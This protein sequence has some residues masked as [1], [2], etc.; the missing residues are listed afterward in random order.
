LDTHK[1]KRKLDYPSEYQNI[2]KKYKDFNSLAAMGVNN[3]ETIKAVQQVIEENK[4]LKLHIKDLENVIEAV[5]KDVKSLKVSNTEYQSEARDNENTLVKKIEQ[6]QMENNRFRT[7]LSSMKNPM[8]DKREAYLKT[9]KLEKIVDLFV[10]FFDKNVARKE[11]RKKYDDGD[12]DGMMDE[13]DYLNKRYY[14]DR[15]S[16]NSPKNYE[17]NDKYLTGMRVS[18]GFRKT[19]LK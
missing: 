4:T 5:R 15:G 7:E 1:Y 19:Y 3:I 17:D 2:Y 10:G 8:A 18:D 13:L 6:L 14:K 9:M 16:S 11:L 12:Y